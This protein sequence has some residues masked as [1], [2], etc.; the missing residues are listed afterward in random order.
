MAAYD[1]VY[2]ENY[3]SVA[4]FSVFL[5]FGL[6]FAK[7]Y[8]VEIFSN[9]TAKLAISRYFL[10]KGYFGS[11]HDGNVFIVVWGLVFILIG[12]HF[13]QLVITYTKKLF[14]TL[15][16][17][18]VHFHHYIFF[19]FVSLIA[20]ILSACIYHGYFEKWWFMHGDG[21]FYCF[22]LMCCGTFLSSYFHEIRND[23][24]SE[25]IQD[26]YER[27]AF[28]DYLERRIWNSLKEELNLP[29]TLALVGERGSGKT[30]VINL[31]ENHILYKNIKQGYS[32][33][34]SINILR[35]KPW[36]YDDS[37]S[38]H[39]DVILKLLELAE[40][41]YI[42]PKRNDIVNAYIS[43]F[44]ERG[45]TSIFSG[46]FNKDKK[47]LEM[48]LSDIMMWVERS[49]NILIIFD[50]LDRCH[51]SEVRQVFRLMDRLSSLK[52]IFI[53]SAL[54]ETTLK[55]LNRFEKRAEIPVRVS[56]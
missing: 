32:L 42:I 49:G 27:K 22:V 29:K 5:F 24:P 53:L 34:E 18:T 8:F 3:P 12:F 28:V 19:T 4:L 48:A 7:I 11:I 44:A 31:L 37:T 26:L 9:E 52:N 23:F 30:F 38:F 14:Y 35:F 50:D 13:G 43:S 1:Y 20:G 47:N 16:D 55:K 36:D 21:A 2:Q 39:S 17:I 10:S 15:R 54:D 6:I 41:Q 33:K 51:Q 40:K 46:F 56:L 45:K 25:V